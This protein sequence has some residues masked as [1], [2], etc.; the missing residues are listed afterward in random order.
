MGIGIRKKL[1]GLG[2]KKGRVVRSATKQSLSDSG[3]PHYNMKR[4]Q[5]TQQHVTNREKR[6][7]QC[8]KAIESRRKVE[9][10]RPRRW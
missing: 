2:K 3:G 8:R 6:R 10:E 4:S 5:G 7:G 9:K 1:Y